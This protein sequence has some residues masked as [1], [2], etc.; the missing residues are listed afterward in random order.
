MERIEPQGTH[1]SQRESLRFLTSLWTTAG[2]TRT[3][4]G[5]LSF[6]RSRSTVCQGSAGPPLARATNAHSIPPMLR[7]LPVRPRLRARRCYDPSTPADDGPFSTEI[8]DFQ[9]TPPNPPA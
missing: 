5:R 3:E 9:R 6:T 2:F 1:R 8:A 4:V 7:V